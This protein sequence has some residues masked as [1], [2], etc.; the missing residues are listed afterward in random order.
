MRIGA[1]VDSACDLPEDWL[2]ANDIVLLPITVR[3]GDAVIADHRDEQAT[4]QFLHSHVAER[5]AEAET[6][7]FTVA[8]VRELFLGRLVVDYDYVL[9]LTITRTRS[10]IHDN[11]E[12]ASFAILNDY[13]PIRAAAGHDSPFALRVVDTGNVFAGQG[14]SAV[15]AVRL[16]ETGQTLAQM[17]SRLDHVVART[18]AYMVPRDLNYLRARTR[19][20]GD[21]SVSFL[22]ATLGTALDIKPILHCNRGETGPVG[23]IK[24]FENATGTLF[25][26]L[27][28]RVG[29]GLITPTMCV[30]YGG[31]LDELRR[32]PGYAGLRSACEAHGVQFLESVM[33]VTGMVNVG[34]GSVVA[35]FAGE[36]LAF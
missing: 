1:V 22:A 30:S 4:L 24:G 21:R 7:P 35:A 32:L 11:T 27:A 6:T 25:G 31:E 15:E 33:S 18:H 28:A 36:P 2:R 19:H 34:K 20:R 16:R 13:K 17:R 9:C 12:Q 10:P 14:V 23:K 5:G 26:K 3:I 8:Q 29:A